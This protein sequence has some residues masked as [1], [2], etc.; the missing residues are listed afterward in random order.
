M[1]DKILKR[2]IKI[3]M[4]F[5]TLVILITSIGIST[6][7]ITDKS[8]TFNAD[9][10]RIVRYNQANQELEIIENLTVNNLTINGNSLFN[11]NTTI[12]GTKENSFSNITIGNG[13]NY[14]HFNETGVL[15]LYGEARVEKE[16]KFDITRI[17]LGAK[18][19]GEETIEIGDPGSNVV[20]YVTSFNPSAANDEEVFFVWHIPYDLDPSEDIEFHIAWK[21]KSTWAGGSYN[22]SLEYIIKPDSGANNTG[23]TTIIWETATPA[24]ANDFIETYFT[25]KITGATNDDMI[26]ARFYLEAGGSTAIVDGHIIFV[27]LKYWVNKLGERGYT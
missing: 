7:V 6:M 16:M 11:G 12:N 8:I 19:P 18:P 10:L 26:F 20:A 24:N 17:K 25:T 9:P 14:A 2:R 21:P 1:K 4:V 27:E 23:S 3:G 15:T 22:W 5:L 13:T